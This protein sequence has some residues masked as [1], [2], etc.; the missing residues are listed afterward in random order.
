MFHKLKN[1][2]II[3]IIIVLCLIITGTITATADRCQDCHGTDGGYTFEPLIIQASTPRVA[4]PGEEFEHV[5]I[6]QHPGEYEA[7]EVVVELNLGS[8]TQLTALSQSTQRLPTMTE[9]TKEV[10]FKLKAKEPSQSQRIRTIVKYTSS[11]HYDPTEIIEVLDISVNIDKILLEPSAWSIEM[12]ESGEKSIDLTAIE[13]V[14][15]IDI[16][17]SS[18]LD[19]IVNLNS[20]PTQTLQKGNSIKLD[21]EAK[22]VGSGKLNII[23]EDSL[24]IPHKVV[25][26]VEVSEDIEKEGKFWIQVGIITGILSWVVL[27]ISLLVGAPFKKV[28]VTLNKIFKTSPIRK[29]FHCGISYIISVL[30]LFHAVVVMANHWYGV[31]LN[32]SYLIANIDMDY[33]WYINLGTI[34]WIFM[35]GVSFTGI[36]WKKIIKI[37]KY[38]AWRWTHNIFTILALAISSIHVTIMLHFRFF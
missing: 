34:A 21:L 30:A 15:N 5:I 38:N 29:E 12:S 23:Y 6:I 4:S 2:S 14:K 37:I 8:A 35:V 20:A 32:N 13:D 1:F 25:L 31:V 16:L 33:G 22:A 28:K 19:K 18:T 9:G 36:F 3:F 27:F 17:P 11:L 26:D 24:G 7:L 10:V